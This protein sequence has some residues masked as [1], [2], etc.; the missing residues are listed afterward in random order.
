M[1]RLSLA[2]HHTTPLPA[3]P[4]S[5]LPTLPAPPYHTMPHLPPCSTYYSL[6]IPPLLTAHL[7]PAHHISVVGKEEARN[8]WWW[9][10][11]RQTKRKMTVVNQM[12]VLPEWWWPTVMMVM[13]MVSVC[14]KAWSGKLSGSQTPLPSLSLPSP[15]HLPTLSSDGDGDGLLPMSREW[16]KGRQA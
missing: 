2:M 7:L 6:P 13:E 10:W 15:P 4:T 16:G 9:W 8:G 12:R 5:H 3:H 11:W 1:G 14:I